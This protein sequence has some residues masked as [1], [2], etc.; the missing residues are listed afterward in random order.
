MDFWMNLPK[1]LPPTCNAGVWLS[2]TW[3]RNRWNDIIIWWK[4]IGRKD[5]GCFGRHIWAPTFTLGL[6]ARHY[7][8]IIG[9]EAGQKLF[10]L[11][12]LIPSCVTV[13]INE[14]GHCVMNL[15][16][17]PSKWVELLKLMGRWWIL[18]NLGSIAFCTRLL[19][20]WTGNIKE[21]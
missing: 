12:V 6:H 14:G 13:P 3:K 4:M 7:T 2:N 15:W 16:P 9:K 5:C 20:F 8:L 1:Q 11:S 10:S 17:F 21:Q 19:D 18:S